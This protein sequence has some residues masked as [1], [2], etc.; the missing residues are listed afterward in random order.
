MCGTYPAFD[1]K[2]DHQLVSRIVRQILDEKL[3][4]VVKRESRPLGIFV[5]RV[6][7]E[8]LN[9]LALR[10]RAGNEGP[11]QRGVW[12]MPAIAFWLGQQMEHTLVDRTGLTERY[13]FTRGAPACTGTS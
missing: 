2:E 1:P 6:A 5:I 4:V 7:P 13:A 10:P 3:A 11:T 9:P 12:T 8:G